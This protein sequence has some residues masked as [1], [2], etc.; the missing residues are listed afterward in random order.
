MECLTHLVLY[1][2]RTGQGWEKWE[3][4]LVMVWCS[5]EISSSSLLSIGWDICRGRTGGWKGTECTLRRGPR[6]SERFDWQC[7]ASYYFYLSTKLWEA[8]FCKA[9]K[10]IGSNL[11]CIQHRET[12][13]TGDF[14]GSICKELLCSKSETNENS[15]SRW[16][17]SLRPKEKVLV[18]TQDSDIE[19]LF[20]I[21]KAKI[22]FSLNTGSSIYCIFVPPR[23]S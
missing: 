16:K 17:L 12:R 9:A 11:R 22:G 1:Q 2:V 14:F 23:Q 21:S 15:H 8:R 6:G 4:S 20:L 13:K 18:L 7:I 3:S 10:L 5:D 19:I